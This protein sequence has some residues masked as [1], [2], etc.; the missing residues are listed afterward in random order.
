MDTKL[1]EIQSHGTS[2]F[3]LF[4]LLPF[5]FCFSSTLVSNLASYSQM[6]SISTNQNDFGLVKPAD[7]LSKK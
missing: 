2:P 5:F 3:Q 1:M 7:Q 6:A 4:E